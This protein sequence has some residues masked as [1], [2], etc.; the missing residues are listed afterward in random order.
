MDLTDQLKTSAARV[1]SG[2]VNA[3]GVL[4]YIT[5]DTTNIL[6]G[7]YPFD[8]AYPDADF[9]SLDGNAISFTPGTLT[10]QVPEPA[11]VSMLAL[12]GL[13]LLRR[14]RR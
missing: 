1:A 12:G 11:S 6:S 3:D 4:A 14:R 13:A 8:L 2:T 10:I 7:S 5:F 9:S